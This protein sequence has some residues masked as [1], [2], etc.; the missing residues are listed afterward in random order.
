MANEP[1]ER[2]FAQ[3]AQAKAIVD[4]LSRRATTWMEAAPESEAHAQLVLAMG[5]AQVGVKRAMTAFTNLPSTKDT[6][7]ET[8]P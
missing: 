7:K 4:R 6:Q 5:A 2:A 3:L 8:T 1:I